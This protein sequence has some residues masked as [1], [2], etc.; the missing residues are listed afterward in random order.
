MPVCLLT[1]LGAKNV[2]YPVEWNHDITS[3]S[4]HAEMNAIIHYLHQKKIIGRRKG[5]SLRHR[6]T[7]FPK[8]IY[9]VSIYK[10]QLRNSRPCNECIC[11]MRLYGIRRVVY[12]TGNIDEPFHMENVA[13]MPLLCQSRGNRHNH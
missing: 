4:T 11:V 3:T 2:P 12:S 6:F 5:H 9:V 13:T 1:N 7:N 8:T 10:D